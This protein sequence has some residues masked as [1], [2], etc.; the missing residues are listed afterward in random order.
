MRIWHGLAAE[1]LGMKLEHAADQAE[2]TFADP[3]SSIPDFRPVPTRDQQ[4]KCQG[5]RE[6]SR[7]LIGVA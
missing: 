1:T 7:E 3:F 5:P 6:S 4:S 2:E